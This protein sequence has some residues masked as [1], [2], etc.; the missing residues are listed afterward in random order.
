MS[1]SKRK[2][3]EIIPASGSNLKPGEVLEAGGRQVRLDRNL[4]AMVDDPGLARDL[5]Q[6]YR[7]TGKKILTAELEAYN[8]RRHADPVRRRHYFTMPEMP[9]KKGKRHANRKSSQ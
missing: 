2:T 3:Y 8:E 7:G 1:T 6:K 9:W 4:S 5:E